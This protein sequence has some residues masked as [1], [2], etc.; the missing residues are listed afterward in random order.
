MIM[1]YS[2]A[3]CLHCQLSLPDNSSCIPDGTSRKTEVNASKINGVRAEQR[4]ANGQR[5]EI[6][7]VA[8]PDF[9]AVS[10]IQRC[11]FEKTSVLLISSLQGEECLPPEK[12]DT[13]S[14]KIPASALWLGI[15]TAA[16]RTNFCELCRV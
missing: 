3:Q 2:L 12:R 14:T 16:Y 15:G 11:H 8:L 1:N 6:K 7:L 10:I 13:E 9:S 4:K 5:K